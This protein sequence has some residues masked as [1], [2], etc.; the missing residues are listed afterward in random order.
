MIKEKA[1]IFQ[2]EKPGRTR[3]SS[4]IKNLIAD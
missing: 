3:G 2:A 4:A 1:Y